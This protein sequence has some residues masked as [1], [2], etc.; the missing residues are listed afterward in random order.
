MSSNLKVRILVLILVTF[1]SIFAVSA[2][3]NVN[4]LSYSDFCESSTSKIDAAE[5]VIGAKLGEFGAF[6]V[7]VD[8]VYIVESKRLW[9]QGRA[10]YLVPYVVTN[11]RDVEKA[12]TS[13]WQ[14]EIGIIELKQGRGNTIEQQNNCHIKN[15]VFLVNA[16]EN[17]LVYNPEYGNTYRSVVEIPLDGVVKKSIVLNASTKD[18]CGIRNEESLATATWEGTMEIGTLFAQKHKIHFAVEATD[19]YFNNK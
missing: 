15:A 1:I 9:Q 14:F 3:S 2:T 6:H 11:I 10:T 8:K 18:S 17:T 4:S 13:K 19:K 12:G 16:N 7:N 5:S